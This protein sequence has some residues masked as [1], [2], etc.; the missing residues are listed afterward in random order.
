MPLLD[1]L[2]ELRNRLMYSVAAIFIAFLFCYY[3]ADEIYGFL[4]QPLADAMEGQENRRLIYTALHEAFFTYVKVAFWA[5]I[6]ISFPIIASQVWMFIA[7]GLYRHERRA[8]LPFLVATPVL[9]FAGGALLYYLVIPLAW[10][11]FLGFETTDVSPGSLPIQLEAKVNEYLSLVMRLIFAFGLSFQLPIALTLMARVGIVSADGLA[12]KRKYALVCTFV[13]AAILT[14]PD[15]ISQVGLALPI[16]VLY[17]ISI[18]MARIVEKKRA[19]REA[20]E[21]A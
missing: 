1:H 9:F 4:V 17:E 15:I 3:F 5:A 10:R 14:P 19:E 13:A 11:F 18:L 20:E 12:A 21:E 2:I 7:P 6:F 16:I 8:F